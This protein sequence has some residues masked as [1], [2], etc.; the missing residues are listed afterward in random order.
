MTNVKKHIYILL[1]IIV[2]ICVFGFMGCYLSNGFNTTSLSS[3]F[4]GILILIVS[5]NEISLTLRVDNLENGLSDLFDYILDTE[6]NI[7]EGQRTI[8]NMIMMLSKRFKVDIYEKRFPFH[9]E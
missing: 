1:A 8:Q 5:T 6:D 4:I 2:I 3:I 7:V 9:K